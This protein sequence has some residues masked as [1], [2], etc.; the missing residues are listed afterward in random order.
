MD[1]GRAALKWL[2]RHSAS[3]ILLDLMMPLMSGLDVMAA[4]AK[5]SHTRDIP[6][7]VVT[8][9]ALREDER[10]QLQQNLAQVMQKHRLSRNSLTE[11]VHLALN[12]RTQGQ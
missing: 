11:Q 4:L 3:L 6:V 5:D 2:E 10:G 8:S 7:I 12:K 9:K 1:S